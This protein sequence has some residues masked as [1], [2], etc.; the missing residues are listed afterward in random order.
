MT[1]TVTDFSDLITII[2]THPEWRVKLQQA[3]FPGLDVQAFERLIETQDRILQGLTNLTKRVE[4]LESNQ[5]VIIQRIDGLENRMGG[6]ENRMGGL[7]GRVEKLQTDVASLKGASY[8]RKFR[9]DGAG[10]FGRFVRRG[11][12]AKNH[13]ADLLYDAEAAG[14]ITESELTQVLATDLLWQGKFR[15]SQDELILVLETSWLAE[16]S[17]VERA[18]TRAAILRKMGLTALPAVS[19]KEWLDEATTLATEQCVIQ[20]INLQVEADTWTAAFDR[21]VSA[22]TS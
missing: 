1:F 16:L 14:Q 8:E 7:D 10:I 2:D 18:V 9:D 13:V 5:Q 12:N 17:D 21:F 20:V 15:H 11:R 3:L 4:G 22:A 6:L 19:G